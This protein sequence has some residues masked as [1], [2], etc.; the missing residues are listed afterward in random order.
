MLN[1]YIENMFIEEAVFSQY[2]PS[3]CHVPST[4]YSRDTDKIPVIMER[5]VWLGDKP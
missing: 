2:L 3:A 1:K 5:T 4:G